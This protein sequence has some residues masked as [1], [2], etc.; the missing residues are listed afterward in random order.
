MPPPFEKGGKGGFSNLIRITEP[1]PEGDNIR[2]AGEDILK[3]DAILEPGERINSRTIALLAALG[4]DRVDVFR[5]P[6]VRILSTGSELAQ[7]GEPLLQGQIY[8]SN[9]PALAAALKEIGIESP[10]IAVAADTEGELKKAISPVVDADVL[11]TIGAVSAGDFDLVP[12]VLKDIGAE[13][14]FH[15]VAIK[16]GK[17]LLYAIRGRGEHAGS[18]LHIFGLPGNPVSALMVFDRFVRPALLKMMGAKE[19][20]RVTKSAVASEDLKG[21]ADK[22]DYLR[23]IVEYRE[24]RYVARSAGSQG[25]A[26]LVPLAKANAVIIIPADRKL[27][28]AGETVLFEFLSGAS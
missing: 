20:F 23:G 21:S 15:K 18:P 4:L 17:P 26:R 19:I 22:E 24:G 6:R 9:G 11:I 1:V 16:P 28:A 13:I 3:G 2:Y 10:E 12:K 7:P 27:I 25:S 5:H 8:N 14:V